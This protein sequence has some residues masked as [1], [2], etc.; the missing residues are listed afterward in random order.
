MGPVT[1]AGCGAICPSMDRGCYAC[2]GPMKQANSPALAR[3]FKMMGLSR[4][5]IKRKF[6]LFGA[7][8]LEFRRAI[9]VYED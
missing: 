7:D 1:N 5:D 2:F 6:T 4:D 8:T 3:K 9:E